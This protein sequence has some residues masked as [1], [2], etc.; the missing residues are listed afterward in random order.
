MLLKISGDRFSIDN[1][2]D[3]DAFKYFVTA[4]KTTGLAAEEQRETLR[5]AGTPEQ[6]KK[7]KNAR[8]DAINDIRKSEVARIEAI[9]DAVAT[10]YLATLKSD[11]PSPDSDEYPYAAIAEI[12]LRFVADDER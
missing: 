8:R 2:S 1:W 11:P 3:E 6:V 12:A 5:I 10:V 4:T 9:W 7:R